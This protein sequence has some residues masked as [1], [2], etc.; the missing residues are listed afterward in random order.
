MIGRGARLRIARLG[1]ALLLGSQAC[2]THQYPDG[3][4]LEGQLEREVVALNQKLRVLEGELATC[5]HGGSP[6]PIYAALHQVYAGTEVAVERR[7]GITVVVIPI[8]VLFADAYSLRFREESTMSLDLLATALEGHPDQRI[9]IEGHT[10]D[11][12][13]PAGLVRRF[14]SHLDLSFQ[15]AAAVMQRL[16][17]EFGVSE[18]RFTVAGRGRWAPIATNDTVAGQAQNQRVEVHIYP[19]SSR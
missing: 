1:V 7:G 9:V 18:D 8:A 4:G 19:S 12:M 14:G 13:L 15:Y 6:G 16:T 11:R 17:E 10:D 2:A 5:T 3:S